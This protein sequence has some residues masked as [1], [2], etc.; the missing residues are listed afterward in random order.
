ML[1]FKLK[2]II[3]SRNLSINKLSQETKISRPS[4]TA[5][6]NNES[7]GVQFDTLEK[8]ME[9]LNVSL[10]DLIG[11][12]EDKNIFAFKSK[13]SN[14]ALLN[15]LNNELNNNRYDGFS[16][17]R[18]TEHLPYEAIILSN[19]KLSDKFNFVVS[20]LAISLDSSN[21]NRDNKNILIT[22][23]LINFY[24]EKNIN[25]K[26]FDNSYNSDIKSFTKK[27]N[28]KAI[29]KLANSIF[30]SWFEKYKLLTD[31]NDYDF[32]DILVFNFALDGKKL[33]ALVAKNNNNEKNKKSMLD[34]SDF[35]NNFRPIGNDKFSSSIT[36][37]EFPNELKFPD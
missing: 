31:E 13:Y 22:A 1:Y 26:N 10:D 30:E 18:A 29:S 15:S 14:E 4:L 8:L 37:E 11:E 3:D 20:P 35:A 32:S 27:L 5:M 21:S 9:V 7:K 12:K 28:A 36:F 6:Y 17:V 23:F 33:F 16:E 24:S 19:D 34:F 2:K 25:N